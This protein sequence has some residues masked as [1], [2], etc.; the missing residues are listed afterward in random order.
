MHEKMRQDKINAII[1]ANNI[2]NPEETLKIDR[3]PV[4]DLLKLHNPK[5]SINKLETLSRPSAESPL[6]SGSKSNLR[7]YNLQI[8]NLSQVVTFDDIHKLSYRQIFR[9]DEFKPSDILDLTE[10]VSDDEILSKFK[11]PSART[12]RYVKN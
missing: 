8:S 1:K 2:S 12:A 4:Q 3:L 10:D 5:Y 11:N 6:K 9:K 7:P